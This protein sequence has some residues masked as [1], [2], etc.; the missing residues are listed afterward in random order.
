MLS[1]LLD[2][3]IIENFDYTMFSTSHKGT[4]AL[5]IKCF[6]CNYNVMMMIVIPTNKPQWPQILSL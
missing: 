5:V 4:K 1:D 2:A 3:G 6:K